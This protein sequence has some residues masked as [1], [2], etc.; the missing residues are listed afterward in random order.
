MRLFFAKEK[1]HTSE[2]ERKQAHP[3]INMVFCGD[4]PDYVRE[5]VYRRRTSVTKYVNRLI[6]EEREKNEAQVRETAKLCNKEMK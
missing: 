2:S 6:H 1:P 4:T 5:A 3:Q